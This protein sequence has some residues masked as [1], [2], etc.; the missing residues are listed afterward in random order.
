MQFMVSAYYGSSETTYAFGPFKSE[1]SVDRF[2]AKLEKE[3]PSA[4]EP[5]VTVLNSP[6]LVGTGSEMA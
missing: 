4:E 6:T 2:I 1:D 5:H 3:V